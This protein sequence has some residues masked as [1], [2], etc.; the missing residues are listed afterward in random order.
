MRKLIS[1]FTGTIVLFTL[2][3]PT[4][5]AQPSLSGSLSG[6]IG[7]G[8]YNVT[9]NCSVQAGQ[10]LTILPGTT[11]QHM[12]NFSWMIY[13]T[14][15]A[16]GTEDLMIE[17]FHQNSWQ[18]W[19]GM[20]FMTGASTASIME[21]CAVRNT[22]FYANGGGLFINNGGITLRHCEITDC[23][24]NYGGGIYADTATVLVI[25]DCYIADCVAGKGGGVFLFGCSNVVMRNCELAYNKSTDS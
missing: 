6:T 18:D 10:T 21:W 15:V 9:G 24:A 8:A 2:L 14:V 13:G 7:P 12:G 16:V 20:K 5:L 3:G 25:E 17:F 22:Y 23:Q 11:L 4:A 19:G 1:I